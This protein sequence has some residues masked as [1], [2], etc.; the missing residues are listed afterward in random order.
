MTGQEA[1][2]YIHSARGRGKKDGLRKITELMHR[3]GDPQDKL[4][5]VHVVGTNGKG[6][7]TSM[8]AHSL[9]AAG[10]RTGMFI[11]PFILDFR[12]RMQIDGEMISPEALASCVEEVRREADQMA[13][14]GRQPTEFELVCA[15]AFV[16]FAR[17]QCEVVV[18]EAG[19]GGRLDSTNIVRDTLAAVICSI[20]LDHVEVLG[21]TPAKIAAEKCGVLRPGIPC[22]CYPDQDLDALAV[23][24]EKAA[25]Q[26]CRLIQGNLRAVEVERMTLEGTD[27]RYRDLSI[28]LP[29]VGRYQI[30]NCVNAVEALLALRARGMNI[31]DSAIVRGI[32]ETFFPVRMEVVSRCPTVILDGAHNESGAAA[33]SGS[34]EGL[35]T[36]RLVILIG[37]MKDKD[38]RHAISKTLPLADRVYTVEPLDNPRAMPSDELAALAGEYCADVRSWGKELDK[39]FADAYD[40]LSPEDTLLVCGSLYVASD[41][42][43]TAR[44]FFE[45]R[46]IP[47]S[48]HL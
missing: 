25:E 48:P 10:Y 39:A 44:R 46:G 38:V 2:D 12:E 40:S 18:L 23:I 9:T 34:L 41:L 24:M 29:L 22:I 19:I 1:V 5:Y 6:S 26:N 35:V 3:L 11:S 20:G 37:M 47:H 21:D 4:R 32:G 42:R 31:P 33:L 15:T 45:G 43:H 28:H 14:E 13:A 7:T 27:L 36:G 30:A 17:E 16:W 8:I